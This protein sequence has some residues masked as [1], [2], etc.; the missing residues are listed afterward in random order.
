MLR[1][2]AP[3]ANPSDYI[4]DILHLKTLGRNHS[5]DILRRNAETAAAHTASSVIMV[6]VSVP[7][8]SRGVA[9]TIFSLAAAIL[10]TVEQ[11]VFL[12]KCQSTENR[13][14]VYRR[15]I[16]IKFF[17]RKGRTIRLYTFEN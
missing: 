13:A 14:T 8:V 10:E 2:L 3:L 11:I 1:L 15:E 5:R 17:E 7:A 12:K 16:I 4:V 9:E 6:P